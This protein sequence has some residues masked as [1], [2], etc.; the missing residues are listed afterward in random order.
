M[1][2]IRVTNDQSPGMLFYHDHG[3]KATKFNVQNGLA[4]LYVIYDPVAE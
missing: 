1:K 3:M 4:G 2:I